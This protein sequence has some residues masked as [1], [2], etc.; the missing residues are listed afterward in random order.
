M[1]ELE[2]T[3]GSVIWTFVQGVESLQQFRFIPQNIN[4]LI[5]KNINDLKVINGSLIGII[6]FGIEVQS[7]QRFIDLFIR[8]ITYYLFRNYY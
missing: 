4:I 3:N 2:F 5:P 1:H 6:S 7:L 8:I